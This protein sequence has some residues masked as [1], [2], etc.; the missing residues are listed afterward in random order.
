M[1]HDYGNEQG[2]SCE[3]V[4]VVCSQCVRAPRG[5]AWSTC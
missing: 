5:R 3:N 4:A 1:W 2:L